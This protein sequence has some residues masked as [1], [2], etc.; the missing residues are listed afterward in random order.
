MSGNHGNKFAFV[1]EGENRIWPPE[2]IIELTPDMMIV[3]DSAE[4][5]KR[6]KGREELEKFVDYII[7]NL[8]GHRVVG[9]WSLGKRIFNPPASE[10]QQARK[11]RML[12]E[13]MGYNDRDLEEI[14]DK[15]FK[16]CDPEDIAYE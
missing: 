13:K 12:L 6:I 4:K 8:N 2:N 1:F 3:E 5:A 7:N 15:V 10:G 9:E 14:T 11:R 16:G